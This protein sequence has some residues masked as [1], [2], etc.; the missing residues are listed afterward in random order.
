[1]RLAAPYS[2]SSA[3]YSIANGVDLRAQ[4]PFYA[5]QTFKLEPMIACDENPFI[6]DNRRLDNASAGEPKD[7]NEH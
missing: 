1:V 6:S 2:R 4:V 3:L 7:Q 5:K